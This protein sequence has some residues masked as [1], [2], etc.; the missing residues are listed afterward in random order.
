MEWRLYDEANNCVELCAVCKV[1]GQPTQCSKGVCWVDKPT[2][3]QRFGIWLFRLSDFFILVN[4]HIAG[5]GN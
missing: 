2:M 4:R 3:L 5:P 1:C